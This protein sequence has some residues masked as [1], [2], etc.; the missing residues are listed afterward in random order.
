[1][2]EVYYAKFYQAVQLGKDGH[3]FLGGKEPKIQNAKM[4]YEHGLLKITAPKIR[5]TYVPFSNIMF[6]HEMD[7]AEPVEAK[8]AKK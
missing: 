1:M 4:T 3:T 5:T 8:K 6:L 2:I 7:K